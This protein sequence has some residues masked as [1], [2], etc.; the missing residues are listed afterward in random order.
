[1]NILVIRFRQMGDAI[2]STALLNS[3]HETFP[4][5][6]IDFVLNDRITPLFEGHP[7]ISN[8][9]GFS[10]YE[11]HHAM[12][13]LR[14]VWQTVHNKHYDVI[15]DMRSTVNTMLF[16]LFSPSS[17]YRIGL[18]KA[19]TA[20]IYNHRIEECAVNECMIDY[21]LRLMEP[22]AAERSL[23]RDRRFTLSIT[24]EEKQHFR[25]HMEQQGVDF[26]RPVALI[27]VTTRVERKTW[28]EP[29]MTWVLQQWLDT[30]PD[31]Q[32]I[33]NYA[34]RKEEENARRIYR[35]LISD[36]RI[37]IDL[38]ARSQR[39]LAAMACHIDFYFG[40]EGGARHIV[41]A[42]GKPSYV[43]VAPSSDKAKWLPQNGIPTE[44]LAVTDLLSAEQLATMTYEQQF[45]AIG[46]ERVWQELQHFI[47]Q[48]QICTK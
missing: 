33:F 4:E 43:I 1:M 45:E 19:Y 29:A 46:R 5:A 3:L 24:D 12:T 6:D 31:V 48:H 27:G 35:Q 18:R 2:L 44:G 42:M 39:E 30:N 21:D 13:Y 16:A 37:F 15:I 17:K 7:A 10:D 14:K 25:Q 23:K 26:S 20:L 38:Q 11:R 22:L 32:F 40:N 9:I 28:N 41:H 36:K 8:I 34:P 47:E